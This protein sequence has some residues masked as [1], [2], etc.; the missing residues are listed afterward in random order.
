MSNI[1]QYRGYA[2]A[3]EFD[4][5][6][7]VFT[8]H[9]AGINDIIGFH[10]DNVAGMKAA[11]HEAVDDYLAACSR[12]GKAPDKPYSGKIMFRIAP[13]IHARAAIA[14]KL[15]GKS[16][17]QWGEEALAEKATRSR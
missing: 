16:L 4:A 17:N 15:S 13:E 3:V 7:E 5:E 14:A 10:A 6:D 12:A 2:A 11:F 9:L 1:L 8:G